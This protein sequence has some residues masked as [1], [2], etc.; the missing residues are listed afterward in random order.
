MPI[1]KNAKKALR[2]TQKRT[3]SNKLQKTVLKAEIA[4]SFKEKDTK[5]LS[6]LFSLTDKAV[7]KG[8]IHKNKAGR[9]KSKLSKLLEIKK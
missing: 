3:I 4:K 7:K 5:N 9:I 6:R 1:I 8:I 2:K